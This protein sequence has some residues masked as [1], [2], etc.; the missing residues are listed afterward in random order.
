VVLLIFDGLGTELLQR[1]LSPQSALRQ[2]A[3]A[4]L[5]SVFPPTTTAVT[6]SLYSGLSPAEH[7]WLGWS[8]YF[9]EYGRAVD[10]FPNRDSITKTTVSAEN[11]A[12]GLMPYEHIFDR[13]TAVKRQAPGLYNLASQGVKTY[14]RAGTRIETQSVGDIFSRVAELCA[15]DGDKFIFSYWPQPDGVSHEYG[16]WSQEV[17]DSIEEID[18]EFAA[19]LPQLRD[20]LIIITADHGQTEID[21]PTLL[22]EY[23]E[24]WECLI[25]PPCVEPRAL[26]FFVKADRKRQ[27]KRS[28]LKAF[29]QD[30]ILLSQGQAL[31]QGIFG[32]GR[33]HPK[34][35]GVL[36][37]FMAIATGRRIL[38]YRNRTIAPPP[39][40][41]FKGHHAGITREELKVPLIVISPN[42]LK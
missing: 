11:A 37:D 16:P 29:G 2:Y 22:D 36:G 25:M 24:I 18:R 6:T 28:F 26:S 17:K 1:H 7:G 14:N 5:D 15:Q 20:A 42:D 19:A 33:P 31:R 13:I 8:L 39:H 35:L 30:F 12:F 10:C 27:F 3:R 32:P 9:K 41:T 23:P 40:P 34:T 21:P 4:D 38:S